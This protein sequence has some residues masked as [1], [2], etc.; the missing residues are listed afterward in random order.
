MQS[1]LDLINQLGSWVCAGCVFTAAVILK[2]FS[3]TGACIARSNKTRRFAQHRT[4]KLI[5]TVGQSFHSGRHLGAYHA[6]H[7]EH[8]PVSRVPLGETEFLRGKAPVLVEFSPSR[9]FWNSTRNLDL[10]SWSL[11][12]FRERGIQTK[13]SGRAIWLL[14][15]GELTFGVGETTIWSTGL[16]TFSSL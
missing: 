10:F 14:H 5:S 13:W 6:A 4:T 16:L 9:R 15:V 2:I 1:V 11:Y 3:R 7:T 12:S 8:F